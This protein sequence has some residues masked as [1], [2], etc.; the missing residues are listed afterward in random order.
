M[1]ADAHPVIPLPAPAVEF[2][3]RNETVMVPDTNRAIAVHKKLAWY[4]PP[5]SVSRGDRE[6]KSDRSASDDSKEVSYSLNAEFGVL[7]KKVVTRQDIQRSKLLPSELAVL[8]NYRLFQTTGGSSFLNRTGAPFSRFR[9]YSKEVP[10]KTELQSRCEF[11]TAFESFLL[12]K[13]FLPTELGPC[14]GFSALEPSGRICF[15]STQ[16]KWVT[17]AEI[18]VDY[19]EFIPGTR[20]RFLGVAHLFGHFRYRN[21]CFQHADVSIDGVSPLH[22]DYRFLESQGQYSYLLKNDPERIPWAVSY[23]ISYRL[24]TERF[25]RRRDAETNQ[26]IGALR[27]DGRPVPLDCDNQD[28]PLVHLARRIARQNKGRRLTLD[29]TLDK[30]IGRA[31]MSPHIVHEQHRKTG[32]LLVELDVVFEWC[33]PK[34]DIDSHC[35]VHKAARAGRDGGGRGYSDDSDEEEKA[36]DEDDQGDT[37]PLCDYQ[38]D[39][40][41]AEAEAQAPTKSSVAATADDDEKKAE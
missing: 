29:M 36:A 33:I 26:T 19:F 10:K 32:E 2:V 35:D 34:H 4:P 6:H 18:E 24:Y 14:K 23:D 16:R 40:E 8:R 37:T 17:Q 3:T 41:E 28:V 13:A 11:G 31:M 15:L 22:W 5:G 25:G 9:A 39:P 7:S 27:V 30:T 1:N 12:P 21:I 38:S 20:L